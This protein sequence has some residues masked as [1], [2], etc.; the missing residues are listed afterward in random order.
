MLLKIKMY[1]LKCHFGFYPKATVVQSY[2]EALKLCNG[3]VVFT[4]CRN[5]SLLQTAWNLRG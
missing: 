5:K 3:H 1:N 2:K 4:I